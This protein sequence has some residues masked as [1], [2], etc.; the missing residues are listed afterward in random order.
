MDDERLKNPSST[1]DYFDEWLNEGWMHSA[2]NQ[3]DH[4]RETKKWENFRSQGIPHDGVSLYVASEEKF[5][6]LK[7]AVVVLI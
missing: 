2:S 7:K 3:L 5:W 1:W 6:R 4:S